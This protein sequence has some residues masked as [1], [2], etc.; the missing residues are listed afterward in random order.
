MQACEQSECFDVCQYSVTSIPFSPPSI[1][2]FCLSY[3]YFCHLKPETKSE[4][5]QQ[6][7]SHPNS[8]G[9]KWG[10]KWFASAKSILLLPSLLR[11]QGSG[12]V[13][14]TGTAESSVP[15]PGK[16][17]PGKFSRSLGLPTGGEPGMWVQGNLSSLAQRLA[18]VSSAWQKMTAAFRLRALI[19]WQ[20]W[21]SS[22]PGRGVRGTRETPAP[23]P[24][25]PPA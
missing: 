16:E 20:G 7:N 2:V 13:G 14:A 25:T 8:R 19:P 22:T 3:G 23:Q 17:P 11:G 18:A 12:R 10:G 6:Q 24:I 4:S 21:T 5:L 1:L 15:Q 9:R